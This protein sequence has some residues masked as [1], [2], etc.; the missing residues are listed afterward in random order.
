MKMFFALMFSMT[1]MTSAAM[2]ETTGP[3]KPAALLTFESGRLAGVDWVER[4]AGRVHTRSELTQSLVI[5]STI[6]LRGDQTATHA[7]TTLTMAGDTQQRASERDLAGA[8]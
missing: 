5:D 8:Q 4:S 1:V 6:D 2:A 3:C 7:A